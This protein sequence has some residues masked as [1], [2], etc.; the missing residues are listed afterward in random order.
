MNLPPRSSVRDL[1]VV[2]AGVSVVDLIGRPIHLKR[3]PAPGGMQPID[4]V[5]LTTGG[6]VPNVGID[7]AKLG[8]RVGAVSRVGNDTFGG[9]LRSRL[10]MHGIMTGGLVLDGVRQTSATIVSVDGTGERS[11]FHARGCMENFRAEDVLDHLDIVRRGRVF[12]FGYYGLL[13]ECDAHLGRMFRA[14]R[15]KTGI[16]VL[17]DTAGVPPKD[18]ATLRSFLPAVDYFIPSYGE[19]EAMT[20]ETDPAAMME[21]FVKAGA[22]GVVGVKLGKDGC[23]IRWNGKV[24]RIPPRKARKIVD[25]TGAGDAFIAGFLAGILEGRNPFD[26]AK[27]GNAVASSSLGAVG[28]ST[29][30]QPLAS[31][32]IR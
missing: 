14:V 13:P 17:L 9:F 6:N 32:R 27:L 8:Y 10:E 15:Q 12:A 11:F 21:A 1:D 28:A 26:A 23:M 5:T 31:Y 4:S 29:A 20:G 3:P 2:V 7:L 25:T 24:R 30:I 18:P 22:Q 16:P 19:G